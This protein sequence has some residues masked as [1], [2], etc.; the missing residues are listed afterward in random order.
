MKYLLDTNICIALIRQK[1]ASALKRLAA[2]T[3]GDVGVSVITVA[4]LQFGVAKSANPSQ[5]QQALDQFL[6]PLEILDFDQH[7]AVVY[8]RIR[9]QLEHQ[10]KPIG[11][12]DLLIAAHAYSLEAI[13][14]TNNTREFARI[15]DLRLEDWTQE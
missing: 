12:M 10:G 6:L 15:P 7:S 14:V 9:R 1:S 3:P 5:N 11:A 4:E 13:L 8:G 2:Q